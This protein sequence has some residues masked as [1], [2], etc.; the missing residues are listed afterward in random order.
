M[1]R[2]TIGNVVTGHFA[3]ESCMSWL[4]MQK[5]IFALQDLMLLIGY[6]AA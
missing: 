3:A 1:P 2:H 5:L 6:T 4:D